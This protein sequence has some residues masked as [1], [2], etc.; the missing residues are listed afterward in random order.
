MAWA[1]SFQGNQT[2]VPN[3]STVHGKI[4]PKNLKQKKPK[5]KNMSKNICRT[6]VNE[7]FQDQCQLE[8]G[9]SQLM[10]TFKLYL[11]NSITASIWLCV[12][13]CGRAANEIGVE[14]VRRKLRGTLVLHCNSLILKGKYWLL[15]LS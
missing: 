12:C 6:I 2:N 14:D 13:V 8:I 11:S 15:C 10:L 9:Q 3:S 5:S 7:T 1:F 4:S